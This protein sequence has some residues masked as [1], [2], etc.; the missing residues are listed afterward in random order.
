MGDGGIHRGGGKRGNRKIG[1]IRNGEAGKRGK[2]GM[3]KRWKGEMGKGK[4]RGREKGV[5][6]EVRAGLTW[7]TGG[8]GGGGVPSRACR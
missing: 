6:E 8:S 3:D 5:M 7:Q 4:K 1:K 2:E